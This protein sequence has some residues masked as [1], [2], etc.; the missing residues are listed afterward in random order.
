M[1]ADGGRYEIDR[2]DKKRGRTK[3]GRPKPIEEIC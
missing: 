1:G 2:Q 3:T